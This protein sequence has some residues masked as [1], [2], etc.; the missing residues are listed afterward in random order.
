VALDLIADLSR[1]E[2]HEHVQPLMLMTNGRLGR[3]GVSA[4][5]AKEIQGRRRTAVGVDLLFD[6][7]AQLDTSLRRFR[8]R[9]PRFLPA[10][11]AAAR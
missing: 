9:D 1:L 5:T 4:I 7:L 11:K 3:L 8:R 10:P 2:L 6:G